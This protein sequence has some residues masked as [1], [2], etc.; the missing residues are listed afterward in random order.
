MVHRA[1]VQTEKHHD[2]IDPHSYAFCWEIGKEVSDI[3]VCGRL[4]GKFYGFKVNDHNCT[5]FSLV[6]YTYCKCLYIPLYQNTALY[7]K[8]YVKNKY[9][10]VG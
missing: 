6:Y 7:Q 10:L 2:R 9:E 8:R 3:I 5:C 4:L 1:P